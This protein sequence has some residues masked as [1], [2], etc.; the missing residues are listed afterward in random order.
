MSPSRGVFVVL[1]GGDSVGKTT[2]ARFLGRWLDR[3]GVD[4]LLTREPGGT[5][6]GSRIRRLVL[7]PASGRIGAKAEALLYAADKAQHLAEVVMP[8]LGR[9]QTVVCDRFVDSTLAYQGAGRTLAAQEIEALARW[10]TD[11][12]QPDLTVL[13]DADP[14]TT[15]ATIVDKDRLEAESLDF[16]RRVRAQFLDLASRDPG[17]YLV[18]PARDAREH[19]AAAIRD[20]LAPMLGISADDPELSGPDGSME[21]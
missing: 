5:A 12:L 1:E 8:A 15:T 19:I 4:H 14:A 18:L 20:R 11:G 6:L 10:S 21:P 17:R 2:Q 7:D 16:H 9:G 3:N 13:L